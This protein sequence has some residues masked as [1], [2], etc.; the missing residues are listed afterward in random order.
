MGPIMQ[1]N[2]GINWKF[3]PFCCSNNLYSTLYTRC[4]NIAWH[5]QRGFMYSDTCF[6]GHSACFC[7]ASVFHLQFF[8]VLAA[9]H[10][11][12]NPWP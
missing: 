8:I 7:N 6:F 11:T 1:A 12:H 3:V 10:N 9:T 5:V 2:C 4:W